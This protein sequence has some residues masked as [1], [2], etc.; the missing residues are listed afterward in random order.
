MKRSIFAQRKARG[1]TL[2]ELLVVIAIIGILVGLLLPAVQ[3]A[4]EAARR[5]QCSNNLK[6][7]GL[8]VHNFESAARKLPHSGQCDSTGSNSTT[9]MIHSTATLL[10]P[11]IEQ[12][13]VYQLFNHD[14]DPRL[15][16]TYAATQSGNILVANGSA[17]LHRDAKGY[18]YDD[19]AFPTGQQ[20]AKAKIPTF[21]CPS[22]PISNDARDPVHSFGGFDYM[23]VAVSDIDSRPTSPTYLARTSTGD[24]A[25]VS[26]LVFGMLNCDGGGIGRVTDGTSNTILCIEDASRAHP[27]VASF[28]GNSARRSPTPTSRA[29]VEVAPFPVGNR[30]VHTWAD[31]DACTNGF[32]GPSNSTGNRTAKINNNKQ[33]MG[34]P[35]ECRW[36]INNCGP[37]D[38]PFAFHTGGANTVMG[39]GSVRFTSENTDTLILKWLVG[40][41]DG[42]VVNSQD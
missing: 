28:G 13:N 1:F 30:R 9:Y 33:P 41:S 35:A 14:A 38:E 18:S 29:V 23:F 31:P 3:A 10:L 34:G 27:A 8:A 21:V 17:Q 16:S 36:S 39:D 19:T 24:S 7:I 2:V 6:Q 20:A 11:Y 32:S 15:S 40:A 12:N 4:R 5:M 26:Q 22:A 37:N 42:N 25:Y